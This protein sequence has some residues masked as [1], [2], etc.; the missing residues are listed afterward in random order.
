MLTGSLVAQSA[1]LPA[2][3][4]SEPE[5]PV[6]LSPFTV[7]TD[8]DRGYTAASTLAGSRL[9]TNLKDTPAV[10]GVITAELINDL[11]G[12]DLKDLAS[13]G[14]GVYFEGRDNVNDTLAF[15]PVVRIR[16]ISSSTSGIARN[17]FLT[18]VPIDAAVIER[19]E[20]PR[21]PNAVLYGDGPLGGIIN[22]NSKRAKLQRTFVEART[23]FD[24]YGSARLALD[25]NGARGRV[26]F[27]F[28]QPPSP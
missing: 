18:S 23:Q 27:R 21:G 1:R 10:I 3:D 26:R 5:K 20:I 16:G 17:Y 2:T 15:A 22:S 19:I 13:F 12:T 14:A 9:N 6:Q 11:G 8:Q 4:S 28:Y 24:N 25:A 7:S